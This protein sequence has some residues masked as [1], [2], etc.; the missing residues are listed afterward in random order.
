M[1]KTLLEEARDWQPSL[2]D[3]YG[4]DKKTFLTHM[5]NHCNG[6]ENPC[7]IDAIRNT[8][9]FERTYERG[10]FQH[11]I[12]DPLR[13]EDLVFIGTSQKG[14]YLVTDINAALETI[15]FYSHRIHSE[16]KHLKNLFRLANRKGLFQS[17]EMLTPDKRW[18]CIYFDESGTPSSNN[19][20]HDP[21]F[22]VTGT[23]IKDK[24]SK[25]L[26][27]RKFDLIRQSFNKGDN[28]EIKSTAF[29]PQIY[30]FILTE[31]STLDYEFASVCFHKKLLVGEGFSYPKSFYKYAYRF[32]LENLVESV[33]T[34][35]LYFDQYSNTNST[36]S[37]EFI[38][39]IKKN[40]PIIK[41]DQIQMVD[42]RQ[43]PGIQL[44]DIISGVIRVELEGSEK[45][46][47]LIDEK[48]IDIIH[49]P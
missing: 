15:Q 47:H 37:N 8:L 19:I 22:V 1:K 6:K 4:K 34:A 11:Q 43:Y 35:D 25:L 26:L 30:K 2:S 41:S 39:Y 21:Y 48:K 33:L 7:S 38:T 24:K 20:D 46:L 10:E 29:K 14:I 27:Q 17:A 45:L 32:L 28:F 5:V 12:L 18:A 16:R 44:S 3:T 31:L 23:L 9:P 40:Q 49:Y 42:S 13:E 36:F